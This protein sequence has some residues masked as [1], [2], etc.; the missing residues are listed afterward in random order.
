MLRYSRNT[1]CGTGT[2]HTLGKSSNKTYFFICLIWLFGGQELRSTAH[3][4]M[5]DTLRQQ[6]LGFIQSGNNSI[7]AQKVFS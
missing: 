3:I 2:I 7:K 4:F 6:Q 1:I 5:R